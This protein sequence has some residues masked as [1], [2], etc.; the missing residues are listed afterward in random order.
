MEGCDDVGHTLRSSGLFRMKASLVR[1]FQSVIKTDGDATPGG[2]RGTIMEV[3]SE[4][5]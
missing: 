2:A 1:V 4:S 3:A 5:S